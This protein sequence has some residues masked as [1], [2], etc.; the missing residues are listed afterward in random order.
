[1]GTLRRRQPLSPSTGQTATT[2]T[3]KDSP[4]HSKGGRWGNTRMTGQ[5]R[6]LS[7]ARCWQARITRMAARIYWL[8]DGD[9]HSWWQLSFTALTSTCIESA[10]LVEP[11]TVLMKI[12]I[13]HVL[14][15]ML[16]IKD[17]DPMLTPVVLSIFAWFPNSR[18]ACWRLDYF[19]APKDFGVSRYLKR[20]YIFASV[21]KLVQK[22]GT[23]TPACPRKKSIKNVF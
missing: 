20:H 21:T 6:N 16:R 7:Y 10:G 23:Y 22:Q 5:Y 15:A 4:R 2:S 3:G 19:S 9:K 1:M 8:T 18:V 11:A 13:P 14:S 12:T 17:Y